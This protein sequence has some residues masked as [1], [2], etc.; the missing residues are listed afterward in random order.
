MQKVRCI[1]TFLALAWGFVF[2]VRVEAAQHDPTWGA[3]SPTP[4]LALWAGGRVGTALMRR[5][6]PLLEYLSVSMGSAGLDSSSMAFRQT[7]PGV[8]RLGQTPTA[9]FRCPSKVL[10]G[11]FGSTT[12]LLRQ[13][14]KLSAL[15]LF[16]Y[17]NSGMTTPSNDQKPS[18]GPKEG[19]GSSIKEPVF[20]IFRFYLSGN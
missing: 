11:F 15:H 19:L 4:I 2:K 5:G 9:H 13:S 10:P 6:L 1:M 17:S 7:L 8:A 18:G 14:W 16:L 12:I 3:I 20:Q